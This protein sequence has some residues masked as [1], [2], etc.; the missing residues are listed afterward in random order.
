MPMKT[1]V[2]ERRRQF[3]ICLLRHVAQVM[4]EAN[5]TSRHYAWNAKWNETGSRK[6]VADGHQYLL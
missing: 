3:V 5:E 4:N 6:G 2:S 1:V